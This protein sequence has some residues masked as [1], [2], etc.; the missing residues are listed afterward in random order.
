M[1]IYFLQHAAHEGPARLA[2][3]LAGMGHSHNTCHLYADE[4]PPRLEDCDALILLDGPQRHDALE[5]HPWLKRE[6]KL[7]MRALKSGKPLLGIG[8]GAQLIA[9]AL[10]AIV[11]PGIYTEA[12]WHTITLAPESPF[13]LPEQFEAFHW[14]RDIFGL[15][16]DALPLGAS[17]ASPVQGFAWDAGRVVGLQCRLEVTASSAAQLLDHPLPGDTERPAG[18]SGQSDGDAADSPYVQSRE[19]I[20]ADPRR[21]DRLAALLD[22]VLVRWLASTA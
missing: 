10:G 17:S 22:R 18:D 3:W 1:H 11:S 9:E 8:L 5:A 12:G 2:D 20:L 14:H 16:E 4:V 21:F 6:K 15:P 13:D 7:I 19:S